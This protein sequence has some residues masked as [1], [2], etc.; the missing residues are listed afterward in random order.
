MTNKD[1]QRSACFIPIK[2]NSKRVPKK[3]FRFIGGKELYKHIIDTCVESNC[4]SDIYVDSDS[5]E[6][7]EYCKKKNIF[8]IDREERLAT[9]SANGNDLMISWE[10]KYPNYD[11][12]YQAFATSPFTKKSTIMECVKLLEGNN[13]YDSVFTANEKCGWYWFE[14]NPINYDPKKLPRSQDAKKVFSETTAIYGITKKSLIENKCRIGK[15]PY[16]LFVDDLE[17]IDIDSE[18]DF[19]IAKFL[20]EEKCLP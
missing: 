11:Y 2:L 17:S 1:S 14:N 16:I 5:L 15:N 4:F 10:L 19:R 18:F 20:M 12:Y 6:V 9:D 13:S 3:N 8:F 7:K